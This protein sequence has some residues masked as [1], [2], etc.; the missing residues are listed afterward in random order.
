MVFQGDDFG[1]FG[2]PEL[3]PLLCKL[4]FEEILALPD[5]GE[6]A[7]SR[8][9]EYSWVKEYYEPIANHS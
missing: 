4:Q 6:G 5:S 9:L 2:S 3:H 7:A 1:F 8:N